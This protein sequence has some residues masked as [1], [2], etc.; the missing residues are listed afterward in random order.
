MSGRSKLLALLNE[1]PEVREAFNNAFFESVFGR[2]GSGMSI[3]SPEIDYHEDIQFAW[4]Q[5]ELD[6]YREWQRTRY[7]W[8]DTNGITPG[9]TRQRYQ[10]QATRIRFSVGRSKK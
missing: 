9:W 3:L 2:E 10:R 4:E 6:R 8:I 7:V 5:N 1:I